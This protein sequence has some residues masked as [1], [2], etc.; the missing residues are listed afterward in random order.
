MVASR[1]HTT[2][3]FPRLTSAELRSFAN[4]TWMFRKLNRSRP[5]SRSPANTAPATSPFFPF[6]I[7]SPMLY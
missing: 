1:L 7:K 6:E 3:V 5:S 2:R 4:C